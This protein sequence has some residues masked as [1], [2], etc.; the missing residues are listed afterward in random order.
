MAI[1]PCTRLLIRREIG[2]PISYARPSH[3]TRLFIETAA[4]EFGFSARSPEIL[5]SAGSEAP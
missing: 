5:M 3:Q 4:L 1:C 2:A